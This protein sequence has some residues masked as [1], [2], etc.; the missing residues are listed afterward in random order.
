MKNE[1]SVKPPGIFADSHPV[2]RREFLKRLGMMGGGIVVYVSAGNIS[3]RAQQLAD[4]NAFFRIGADGRISCFTGKIEM[5]QGVITSLAQMLADELVVPLASVDMVMGDTL[6]CPYDMGTFGS[7]STPYFGVALRQAAAEARAALIQMAA[8]KLSVPSSQLTV[9]DGQI[10]DFKNPSQSVPYAQLTGGKIIER[11][12]KLPLAPLPASRR[13]VSGKAT[14]RIDARQKVTGDA[15]FSGDIRVP[16]ML[17]ARILRPPAHGA[18]LRRVNLEPAKGIKGVKVIRDGDLIA[19]LHPYPDEA[20]KA[21]D[22]I[23]AEWQAPEVVVD[24]DNLFEHLVK[25]APPA[26]TIAASGDLPTGR[27]LA[28]RKF[29][30]TYLNHYVAHAPMEPHTA[31]VA[32]EGRKARVWASTQTPFWAQQEAA[33]ALRLPR[34]NVRVITPFVGGGFGGK[35]RNQQVIEA[36]RLAR[37]TGKPVQV[38]WTRK[39]E[40]FYDTFRPAAVIKVSSGLDPGQRM[41]YWD[42][43][44]YF[45]G[46]R[47]SQPLY[48]IPHYRVAAR[49]G[50]MGGGSRAHPFPVGAWRGPGSNTNVFAMESQIDIMAAAAGIDPL[51]F[52]LKH[53]RD[54]RMRKVLTAAAEKF[55]RRFVRT[56]SKRGLG[57]ACTDYK[58]TYVATMAEVRVD[59]KTGTVQVQRVVC[60]QDTGEVI[61]PDGVRQQIEGCI[62]MGL[63]YVLS[64]EVRFKGGKILDENFDTYEL[65]R[66]SWLPEIETVLVDNTILPPQGCGEPAIT[67]MGAVI[68]NAVYDATGVR[69]YELPMTPARIKMAIK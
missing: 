46:S 44:N 63:G 69:L 67:P 17:Y 28:A 9:G 13:T 32:I 37:L 54:E 6:L 15:R 16:G 65:P 4:F 12:L 19:A 57:I 18:I 36:A 11:H 48:D 39:E 43:D 27:N 59:V 20:Q 66:F 24:H 26:E 33:R 22:M 62:T 5:G 7:M 14:G 55:G 34:Q 2:T 3:T 56:P 21:L 23:K 29:K 1:K 52:R 61:N 25:N 31:V 42:Y 49:G 30:T 58:G 68:A 8:E 10:S 64:E 60:A 51:T 40:F 38:D 45:A 41:V 35:T 53:L 47:S 50:W